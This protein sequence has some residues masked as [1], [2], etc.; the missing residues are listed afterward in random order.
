M[1]RLKILVIHGGYKRANDN[2]YGM[3]TWHLKED[4]LKKDLQGYWAWA[5]P[6]FKIADDY[7]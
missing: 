4:K 2:F 6:A 5:L 1:I 7:F 3:L